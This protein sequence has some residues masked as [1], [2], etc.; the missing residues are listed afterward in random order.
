MVTR[1]FKKITLELAK[2]TKTESGV[3]AQELPIETFYYSGREV[4]KEIKRIVEA[5]YPEGDVVLVQSHVEEV[6][7]GMEKE[8]FIS[9]AR[10]VE[11]PESQ[12]RK[13]T[14]V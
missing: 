7:L 13:E 9:M 2:L 10:E 6:V 8:T 12:K 11:R 5:R 4:R 3:A 1:S 14:E